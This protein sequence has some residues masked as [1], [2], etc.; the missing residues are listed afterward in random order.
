MENEIEELKT[1]VERIIVDNKVVSEVQA[2][3]DRVDIIDKINEIIRYLNNKE[4]NE[5]KKKEVAI[6]NE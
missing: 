2:L 6:F 4:Y 5:K 1:K 3:P